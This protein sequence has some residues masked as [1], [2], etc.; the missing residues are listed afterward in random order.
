M[1]MFIKVALSAVFAIVFFFGLRWVW[2]HQL[3]LPATISKASGKVVAP[4]DW[5]ATRDPKKIYQDGNTVGD[6]TGPVDQ[7]GTTMVFSQLANTSAF[8]ANKP[9]E[10]QRTKLRVVRVNASIGMQSDGRQVLMGV[11]QGVECEILD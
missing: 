3:D 6:V 11:L 7:Q 9:F 10:Y 1:E 8:D 2:T 4:P 5:V